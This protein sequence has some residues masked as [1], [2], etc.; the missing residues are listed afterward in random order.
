MRCLS[1]CV[2]AWSTEELEKPTFNT[3]LS[4]AETL[5]GGDASFSC[6]LAGKPAPRVVWFVPS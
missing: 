4:N 1:V 3:E 5:L 2:C 6:K